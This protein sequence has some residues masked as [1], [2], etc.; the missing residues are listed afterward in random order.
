MASQRKFKYLNVYKFIT[1]G[2]IEEK[3]DALLEEKRDLADKIV[4]SGSGESWILDLD[5]EKLKE[6]FS[7]NG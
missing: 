4:A 3:I 2:T 1:I 6:L 5:Q 7:F